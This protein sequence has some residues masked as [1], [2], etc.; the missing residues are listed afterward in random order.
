MSKSLTKIILVV[1]IVAIG[2]LTVFLLNRAPKNTREVDIGLVLEPSP[3]QISIDD[4]IKQYDLELKE[5]RTSFYMD[6]ETAEVA[7]VEEE[8]KRR[9]AKEEEDRRLAKE[10]ER[11]VAREKE[12]AIRV[13]EEKKAKEQLKEKEQIVAKADTSTQS[14]TRGG[15]SR[16][17]NLGTFQSTAYCAC[18]ICTGSG[19]VGKTASGTQVQAGRTIAVDPNVIPL[20]TRVSVDGKIYVAEDT[21]SAI[22]GNI[23]DIYF[24]S[25]SEALSWGRRNV[26][27]KI[28]D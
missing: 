4:M 28:L 6:A 1:G 13:A 2:L 5:Q 9:I 19:G 3:I 20:G 17:R 21:G 7:R 15:T 14:P 25:H 22:K 8:E 18:S 12:E 27:V 16:G 23:V 11:R 24:N 10:E 26:E